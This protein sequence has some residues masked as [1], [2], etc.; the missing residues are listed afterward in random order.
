MF[1]VSLALWSLF[2]KTVTATQPCDRF[3]SC[4][5]QEKEIIAS[6]LEEKQKSLKQETVLFLWLQ[7]SPSASSRESVRLHSYIIKVHTETG[8]LEKLVRPVWPKQQLWSCFWHML[9][10]LKYNINC[11]WVNCLLICCPSQTAWE[12]HVGWSSFGQRYPLSLTHTEKGETAAWEW[13]FKAVWSLN[14]ALP[15]YVLNYS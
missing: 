8:P 4:L 10:V 5:T 14:E 11:L 9:P 13:P 7:Q 12:E 15:H 2:P 1:R 6:A 3:F